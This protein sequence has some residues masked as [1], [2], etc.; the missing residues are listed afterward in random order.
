MKK[1]ELRSDEKT[2][3]GGGE[4]KKTGRKTCLKLSLLADGVNSISD[5]PIEY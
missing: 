5:W 3:G 4:G 1:A 2:R